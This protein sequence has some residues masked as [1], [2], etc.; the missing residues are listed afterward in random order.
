[1]TVALYA[2]VST[3]DQKCD[4]QLTELRGYAARSGWDVVEYVDHG[5]SGTKRSRPALDR[6]MNDAR[7]KKFGAVLVWK[8]D[9][10]G[11]SLQ[12]LVDNVQTLDRAGVRFIAVTQ[13]IDTD[14]RSPMGKFLMH[15]FAAFA[16]FE[17]DLIVERVKA[18][19]AEAKRQGK[20]CGRPVRVFRRDRVAQMRAEGRSWRD[21]AWELKLP[22]TT[23]RRAVPKVS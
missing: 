15:L 10:F 16:E 8:M 12:Q 21:I 20:H 7:L 18:G 3:Q 9:R 13:S 19:V 14:E 1:M 6:L 4:L 17:R 22:V 23:V 5:V 2:R 11:R